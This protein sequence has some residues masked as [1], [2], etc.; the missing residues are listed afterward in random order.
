MAP[1]VEEVAEASLAV[2]AKVAPN[3]VAPEPGEHAQ[4]PNDKQPTN[5]PQS[6]VQVPNQSKLAKATPVPAVRTNR[7]APQHPKAPTPIFQSSPSDF[8]K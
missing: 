7:Y 8:P 1:Y 2:S 6:T 3:L 4:N 5:S